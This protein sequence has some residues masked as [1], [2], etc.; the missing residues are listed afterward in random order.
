MASSWEASQ[1]LADRSFV[2][3]IPEELVYILQKG[4]NAQYLEAVSRLALDPAYTSHVF[5]THEVAFVDICGRWV[6]NPSAFGDPLT[7]LAALGKI[8]PLAP[9]LSIFATSL[10][11]SCSAEISQKFSVDSLT[12]PDGFSS[13]IGQR[14]LL[15]I[16]RLLSFDGGKFGTIVNPAHVQL[17][18]R[19]HCQPLQY[20]AIRVLCLFLHASNAAQEEMLQR[21][22]GS[23]GEVSG[24]W[25]TQT[26][27]YL[28]L[29]LWENKR[30]NDL[31]LDLERN[32]TSRQIHSAV[33]KL[34]KMVKPEELSPATAHIADVLV[35]R[36]ESVPPRPSSLVFTETPK[37]NMQSLVEAFKRSDSVLV[38]GLAGTGK[39]TLVYDLARELGKTSSMIT[40]HLNEQTDTKLLI[41][42]HTSDNK[43]KTLRWQPGVLTTA[44]MEGR[45]VFVE[46]LDRAPAEILSTLL[47]LLKRRELLIPHWSDSIRAADGFRLIATARSFVN[48]KGETVIPCS[49]SVSFRHWEKVPLLML[50]DFELAT[51]AK[52][53][54][55][56][57]HAYI[58]RIMDVYS[59][60]ASLDQKKV[61]AGVMSRQTT[62]DFGPRDLF[63]C[64][65][66]LEALLL[67]DGV[68]SGYEATSEATN[69]DI[70]MEAIDCFATSMQPGSAK[71]AVV[72]L[73]A[74]RMHFPSERVEYCLRS[75]KPQYS[76]TETTLRIGRTLLTRK[77][78]ANAF[79]ARSYR[80]RPSP[81]ALNN[82]ALRM[83]ESVG[84]AVKMAE[85]CLLIGETGTGKTAM[86]QQ[87]ATS[88]GV[89]LT[90]AN[91]SQQSE[92]SDLLGG[93]KP[94]NLRTL[95]IP[96]QEQFHELFQTTFSS[97]RNERY[98]NASAKAVA[99]GRWARALALWKEGV[100]TVGS[101]TNSAGKA[102]GGHRSKK[103]RTENSK[104][105]DLKA[106]WNDLESQLKTFEMHLAS[107]SK[108]FAF[109][110]VEGNI[111]KAA[112]NGN[113][114]LLDEI[115]L[116]SPDTL[117]VLADLLS[118][119]VG[120]GPSLLLSETG[121]TERVYAHKDFR[122]FG[123]M[124]PATDVGKRDLPAS[125]R[126]RFTE[127]FVTSPEDD[128]ESLISVIQAYLGNHNDVDIRVAPD[129]A[130]AYLQIRQ[131]VHNNML[132]DGSNQTPHFSLRTL[133]R[134][135]MYA[136]DIAPIYGLRRALYEGFSMSFLTLLTVESGK[137][138]I[139]TIEKYIL[140]SQKSNRTLLNQIRHPD[141]SRRYVRF[142]H[143]W[144]AQGPLPME[145]RPNYI[146]TPF[147]E[148][149]LLN[150][151]RATMTR[152]FP[153]LL[154][155]P[156]SSGKTSMVEYLANISGNKFIRINNHEHT[157]L[158][159]YIGTYISGSDGNLQY[160]EGILVRALREGSW[161][162][163]DELNLAPSDV[164]EAL[165]RLLD[166]NREL[167]IPETQQ[168]VRPHEN[169]ML[170]ATQNPPGMY[171]GRKV[172]SRAFRNRFLEL[173]FDDIPEEELETILRERAQ[174][175]P[176]FCTRIV[177]VYKR[178]L[179]MR[180]SGRVFEQK[181]SYITLRDLFKWAMRPADDR[182]QLA[183]NGFFLLAER[184]RSL[185]ERRAV[186]EIIEEIMKVHIDEDRLYSEDKLPNTNDLMAPM[187]ANVI[188]TR[189][190]RRLYVLVLEAFNNNEPVLFVGETG[191]GKTTVCQII[192]EYMRTNLHTVNA[193]QNMETGDLIGSQ[194][195]VRNKDAVNL[196][197]SQELTQALNVSV[198]KRLG[199]DKEVSAL[200][201]SYDGLQGLEAQQNPLER[202]SNLS[203]TGTRAKALFEWVD[204]SL[205]QAMRAGEHF[206]LDEISLAED[207]V[208]ER[209]NSVL[210]PS[211]TL[212][213]AEKGTDNALVAADARFQFYATMNPGG[214]YGKKELSPALRN[215][216][217]EIWVPNVN[218]EEELLE[219][220][221][222]KLA[223][224][225]IGFARPMVAFASW[226]ASRYSPI[227][228]WVSIRDLLTWINFVNESILHDSHTT[229]LHGAAL[230]YIDSLGADPAAKLSISA[231]DI[232]EERH[233]TLLKLSQLFDHDMFPIYHEQSTLSV[234]DH[235]LTVGP[236]QLQVDHRVSQDP[237]YILDAPT[238]KT[239]VLKIVRA[240]QVSRSILLEGSPGVG[241]TTLITAIASTIGVPLTRIN[242]SDQTDLM[243]LFG[244]DVPLEGKA[245]GQFGWRQAP[246]LRAMTI[247]EWVLLDEMNLASQSVLEGLNA[248]LDH[249]GE[250][251]VSELNQ[252]FLKHRNFVLFAAQ[253]PRHQGGGRKG[254]PASFV[255]RFRV[256]Y[257]DEFTPKD[258]L[259]I[260]SRG[261]PTA[262]KEII[263]NVTQ[264]ITA[265]SSLMRNCSTAGISGG[266]FELNLRDAFRWLQLLTSRDGFLVAGC[267]DD[268]QNLLFLQRLRTLED[269]N[270]VSE[271][272]HQPINPNSK[273]DAPFYNRTSTT[274]QVG[275]GLLSNS[276]RRVNDTTR[277]R[278]GRHVPLSIIESIVHCVQ[279]QWPCLLVGPSG[280]GKASTVSFLSQV[281]G[282]EVIFLSLSPDMDT[283]DLIGGYEQVDVQ[284]KLVQPLKRLRSFSREVL[285]ERLLAGK[286]RSQSLETL[287]DISRVSSPKPSE[288][289]TLL[290][291]CVEEFPL[292]G[293]RMLLDEIQSIMQ[294][295]E[296]DAEAHFE[297]SDGILVKAL[298]NGSW[299][300]LENANL[301]N[302]SVLDRLNSLLEPNGSL[303]INEQHSSDGSP[304][305]IKPHPSFRLFLTMDPRHGE[306]SR[307]M[308]NRSVELYVPAA[309]TSE[310]A[311]SPKCI[312]EPRLEC[313]KVFENFS[314]VCLPNELQIELAAICFDHLRLSDLPT[315]H[316]WYKQVR[317]G[318]LTVASQDLLPFSRMLELYD[319]MTTSHAV[320]LKAIKC[321]YKEIL[322]SLRLEVDWLELCNA[323]ASTCGMAMTPTLLT[324]SQT[325]HPE[326]NPA[327]VRISSRD[328]TGPSLH[329]LGCIFDMFLELCKFEYRLHHL[330]QTAESGVTSQPEPPRKSFI[331]ASK[332][333]ETF[334]PVVVDVLVD[335]GRALR[336]A[337]T[338][339]DLGDLDLAMVR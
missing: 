232:L 337:V 68:V 328:T 6:S 132:V 5:V 293:F 9:H 93:Y 219:I 52:H 338:T 111:V 248:C 237:T 250:I 92:A 41:G 247:G 112:R 63:R 138:V 324:E 316:R 200:P 145:E 179:L 3:K 310:V 280:S 295:A 7:I 212:F 222:A 304:R 175:A 303:H 294:Q 56:I 156:T 46:D 309:V 207:S 146:I 264:S 155:G 330:K 62:R 249:R 228:K 321:R 65:S 205:V 195:P 251:Y 255:N 326:N 12:E 288:V 254:L 235:A 107:G 17:M 333:D 89:D 189:S 234:T 201:E 8:L 190:M 269:V 218:E 20:L 150:L 30:L 253:N 71:N 109:S 206:L 209:L 152:R 239:N 305:I 185:D 97:G 215:R 211:R 148:R 272:L 127:I 323:Q 180:Q 271:R 291:E 307:A 229:I 172:L 106:R 302:P 267:P 318:L 322:V 31:R 191:S 104:M 186:R 166:D 290:R 173:R 299:L 90:V 82:H 320:I 245:A 319:H 37:R 168:I 151:V 279:N 194:R 88:I 196:Q 35:S 161:I 128:S 140:G 67:A 171:G 260:C 18:L 98:I 224:P 246:F 266:P 339:R 149:N 129:V 298:Q 11:R 122:I 276:K 270:L 125:L 94:V 44:V 230:V 27:D 69:D 102:P 95:A 287:E 15:T 203:S 281:T 24:A 252:K 289:F 75:R 22:I 153:V 157:D 199:P 143:Y 144:I 226:Y 45:W 158:Q 292:D 217:T 284:R 80:E 238:T 38:T 2:K 257:F 57:L 243:D 86:I 329:W 233:A 325:I 225:W 308:R 208:L 25:E 334:M 216:F 66:R 241:K 32:R 33:P 256:V 26:I 121:N 76:C 133:T 184:V 36:T 61:I 336:R 159:E 123:A 262:P 176:S 315:I 263:H 137:L 51:I 314:W 283:I 10:L 101:V 332:S 187:A 268:Y 64:C 220:V 265:I 34:V 142:Q 204:G 231:S 258:Q 70:F 14:D 202:R 119:D 213:L 296:N 60:L 126:S 99:K 312:I 317:L 55:P 47:P 242:L 275:L 72:E 1:L 286:A 73:I 197:L 48:V 4:S 13:Q 170:F 277:Q 236:F 42:V 49:N 134:T 116:A 135:L 118:G 301:C 198:E 114:V 124:N 181:H 139:S 227:N 87:L 108:G 221:N 100:R 23:S 113:W 182:E 178:L 274:L 311:H 163:L 164:L 105:Q 40:L 81:Y 131:L 165:N 141:D 130:S 160:Q 120:G 169:F 59:C 162:V 183:I 19:K 54:Y 21:Y 188:W 273:G 85:P 278:Y 78:S 313:F 285:V 83:L 167:L 136:T 58:D 79:R 261:F 154:Q 50:P 43:T 327:L 282:T 300:V 331:S 177:S 16:F 306:L 259:M 174:I 147:V 103:R 117:E 297:W 91:L 192:A 28:F 223:S 240:L 214:D 96:I 53:R 210:E 39:T 115:N 193:H 74:Q 244:S 335:T 84:V 77:R 110:F 29:D